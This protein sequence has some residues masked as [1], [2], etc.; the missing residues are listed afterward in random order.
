MKDLERELELLEREVMVEIEHMAAARVNYQ[1]A[2]KAYLEKRERR[3]DVRKAL[4][5]A[6]SAITV[7]K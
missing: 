6:N 3:D 1:K 4:Q 5:A 2:E 7:P